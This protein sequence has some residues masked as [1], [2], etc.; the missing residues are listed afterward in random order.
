MDTIGA[1][2]KL[3]GAEIAIPEAERSPLGE[4]EYY[5]SDLLGYRLVDEGSGRV[6]GMVTGWQ[7]TAGPVLLEVDDG[8][9]LVPF[10]KSILKAVDTAGREI[11]AELPDG[12][13]TLNG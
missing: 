10:A 9:V 2:E 5:L 13:E 4:G 12:L 7:E 8:R 3:V 6:L 1:A 11:R